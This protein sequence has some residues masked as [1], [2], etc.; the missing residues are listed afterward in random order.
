VRPPHLGSIRQ[1]RDV[2]GLK[3]TGA[4]FIR[5]SRTS[6][7][8]LFGPISDTRL[9]KVRI[10]RAGHEHGMIGARCFLRRQRSYEAGG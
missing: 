9:G 7:A 1:Q 10:G 4:A 5:N 6:A 2:L 8:S 3:R